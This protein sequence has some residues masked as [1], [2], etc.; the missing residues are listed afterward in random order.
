MIPAPFIGQLHIV[1][2]GGTGEKSAW[3]PGWLG[4][5]SASKKIR[6]P[7][8]WDNCLKQVDNNCN[9]YLIKPKTGITEA[10]CD[11]VL[12]RQTCLSENCLSVI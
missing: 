8:N 4:S 5:K 2:A 1:V 3:F 12:M 7:A 11:E 6:L 10:C 9:D